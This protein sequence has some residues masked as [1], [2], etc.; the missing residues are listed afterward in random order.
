VKRNRDQYAIP[1]KI[2]SYE[3]LYGWTMDRIG[4]RAAAF[5]W[6]ADMKCK[7]CGRLIDCH[8]LKSGK[9]IDRYGSDL[10]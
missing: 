3:E 6:K 5:L 8:G 1:L 9:L 7:F 2:L 10:S 4:E